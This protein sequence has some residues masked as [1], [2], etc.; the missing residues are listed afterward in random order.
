[1]KYVLGVFGFIILT[2]IAVVLLA[3]TTG[4]RLN[5]TQ[6]GEKIVNLADYTKNGVVT[7]T[8][9]SRILGA[10]DYREVRIIIS[11][12][13]RRVQLLTGYDGTIA[14]EQ[15]FPNTSNA[16]EAFLQALSNAGFSRERNT[17]NK[18]IAGVCPLGRRMIYDLTAD[19]KD[20]VNLWSTSCSSRDG[21]FG[22]DESTTLNLFQA[23]IPGYN[24]FVSGVQF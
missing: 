3:T 8:T 15:T 7:Y 4:N 2:I 12:T 16:F 23:Q 19:N 5:T 14:K 24:A 17:T 22:G 1:M 10:E 20:V 21:T 6:E 18:D 11:P 13:E 9:Q